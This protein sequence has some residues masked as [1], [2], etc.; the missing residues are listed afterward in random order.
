L[1]KKNEV[2]IKASV[3]TKISVTAHTLVFVGPLSIR[4]FPSDSL[5][6]T[7][8]SIEP[9][10]ISVA[11]TTTSVGVRPRDMASETLAAIPARPKAYLAAGTARIEEPSKFHPAPSKDTKP[12]QRSESLMPDDYRVDGLQMTYLALPAAGDSAAATAHADELDTNA[13]TAQS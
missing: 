3:A 13:A 5:A 10:S 11:P 6:K 4:W 2:N 12:W 9:P 8:S 7:K 1:P